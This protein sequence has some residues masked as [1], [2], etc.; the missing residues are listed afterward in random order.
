MLKSDEPSLPKNDDVPLDELTLVAEKARAYG[1]ETWA[2]EVWRE[3]AAATPD[4]LAFA[5]RHALFVLKPEAIAGRAG[6]RILDAVAAEGFR[7]VAVRTIDVDRHVMRAMWLYKLNVATL[8]R[9]RIQEILQTSCPNLGVIVLDETWD[10]TMPAAVRL[11]AFKGPSKV[12]ERRPDHLRSELGVQ[13]RLLSFLH[14]TDDPADLVRELGI[15]FRA[16][17]RARVIDEMVAGADRHALACDVVRALESDVPYHDLRLETALAGITR[18][19][20]QQASSEADASERAAWERLAHL[21]ES[22]NRARAYGWPELW[23]QIEPRLSALEPWDV[24]V[25]GAH[26]VQQDIPG[27]AP[28]LAEPEG[29][30][31]WLAVRRTG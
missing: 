5:H 13:N 6:T 2:R 30:A 23:E 1:A 26:L 15:F 31:A 7:P 11:T 17:D 12:D 21:C 10:G 4:P 3:L 14:T 22:P 27:E 9:I 19:V 16:G 25:A 28:T 18:R 24:I 29:E 20:A 8:E